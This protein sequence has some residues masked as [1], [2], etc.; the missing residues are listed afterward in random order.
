[1]RIDVQTD[2]QTANCLCS[3]CVKA[4]KMSHEGCDII[5]QS[6]RDSDQ[7][8]H[9]DQFKKDFCLLDVTPCNLLEI[10]EHLGGNCCLCVQEGYHENIGSRF[11]R[12]FFH[13]YSRR[14]HVPEELIFI[15]MSMETSGLTI[16]KHYRF[17]TVFGIWKKYI[18][19]HFFKLLN[20]LLCIIQL[21]AL[22]NF[23][24]TCAFSRPSRHHQSLMSKQIH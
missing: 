17:Y 24:S 22:S 20:V 6:R 9:E 8:F 12:K 4:P 14:L 13:F 23:V 18:N 5:G 11:A 10:A 1:M 16:L 3:C 7:V 21:L 19:T 15:V 2:G